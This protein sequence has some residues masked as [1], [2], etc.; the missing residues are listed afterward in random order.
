MHLSPL[1]RHLHIHTQPLLQQQRSSSRHVHLY[2]FR[3]SC[4]V[5]INVPVPPPFTWRWKLRSRDHRLCPTVTGLL[6][7]PLCVLDKY[8]LCRRT[9][10]LP[11]CV[12]C[13][14]APLTNS[15]LFVQSY[16]KTSK[17]SRGHNQLSTVSGVAAKVHKAGV[18][19]ANALHMSHAVRLPLFPKHDTMSQLVKT[20]TIGKVTQWSGPSALAISCSSST[21]CNPQFGDV[22]ALVHCKNYHNRV[23]S[24]NGYLVIPLCHSIYH[25][26]YDSCICFFTSAWSKALYVSGHISVICVDDCC[27]SCCCQCR[28]TRRRIHFPPF[29]LQ[30]ICN[31][32][33][34]RN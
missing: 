23:N 6:S 9:I 29:S 26:E 3:K 5:V 4:P 14:L 8:C 15:W 17:R 34:P 7:S 18:T 27:P 30:T 10:A 11:V 28:Q 16:S 13:F 32:F 2:R 19:S 33:I 12:N 22:E 25:V 31:M 20:S 21:K 24:A 1:L